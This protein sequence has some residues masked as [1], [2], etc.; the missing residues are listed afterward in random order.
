MIADLERR[1]L[2]LWPPAER[3]VLD[4][5]ELAT[6][7]GYTRRTN[8][9]QPLLAGRMGLEEKIE[10]AQLHFEK[11][12]LPATF[13]LTSAAQPVGL[14]AELA[15]HGYLR[16]GETCVLVRDLAEQ[17]APAPADTPAVEIAE[18]PDDGWFEA[19]VA[20]TGV[21]GHHRAALRGILGR[22]PPGSAFAR[23][24]EG[25]RSLALGL[26]SMADGHMYLAEVVTHPRA[27][28]RGLARRMLGD[29]LHHALRRGVRR[30]FL[31][32]VASN[33]PA[34]ALY[35]ELG[36]REAYRY[37]YREPD[38]SARA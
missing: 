11:R 13:K 10:R 29:L 1:T 8:S 36:F 16:S 19:C 38:P 24:R 25:G 22:V 15:R 26:G 35:A 20:Q 3:V 34:R 17:D 14:D 12:G 4:G 23:I 30:A 5:W 37:W 31:G 2:D 21:E 28:R 6:S 18:V 27:R 7:G 32:M 33:E 9:V